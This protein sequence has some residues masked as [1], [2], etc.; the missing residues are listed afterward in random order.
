VAEYND[1][2]KP[3]IMWANCFEKLATWNAIPHV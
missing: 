2:E 1:N 3:I